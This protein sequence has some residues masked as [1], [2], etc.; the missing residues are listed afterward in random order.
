VNS[1]QNIEKVANEMFSASKALC[2]D[3]LTGASGPHW[4]LRSRA[5][6]QAHGMRL[7]S[8]LPTNDTIPRAVRLSWLENAYSRQLFIGER[9]LP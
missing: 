3:I 4:A 1:A 7:M 5:L 2:P 6:L 9:F 8:L